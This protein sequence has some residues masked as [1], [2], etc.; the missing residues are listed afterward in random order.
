MGFHFSSVQRL[1]L[2]DES[3]VM[4]NHPQYS[5]VS[6]NPEEDEPAEGQGNVNVQSSAESYSYWSLL[7]FSW[8]SKTISLSNKRQL[9][10]SDLPLGAGQEATK[11][12]TERLE[13]AWCD[14]VKTKETP[15]LW[16]CIPKIIPWKTILIIGIL[17]LVDTTSRVLQVVFLSQLLEKLMFNGH[18]TP[19]KEI[20]LYAAGVC[21]SGL[22]LVASR[23]QNAYLLNVLGIHVRSALTGLVHKKVR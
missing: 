16:K 6:E 11:L 14:A 8:L 13:R 2:K 5:Q 15:Q 7:T 17:V 18:R 10:A 19:T 3:N 9:E 4:K 23:S 22:T 21:L 1:D 20:Y 12:Y